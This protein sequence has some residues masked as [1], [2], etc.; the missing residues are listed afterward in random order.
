MAS[1]INNVSWNMQRETVQAGTPVRHRPWFNDVEIRDNDDYRPL[2]RT[3]WRTKVNPGCPWELHY[4]FDARGM[5]DI[6][7]SDG[8][9][10]CKRYWTETGNFKGIIDFDAD[11][12]VRDV[13]SAIAALPVRYGYVCQ[14]FKFTK[15]KCGAKYVLQ[16]GT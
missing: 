11:A 13:L 3:E 8:I 2:T 16:Y 15:G 6:E 10:A 14:F 1:I 5:P 12:T 7:Y 4:E 9:M